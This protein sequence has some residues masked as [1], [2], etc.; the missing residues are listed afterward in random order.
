MRDRVAINN[1][2]SLVRVGT[3]SHYVCGCG[4]VLSDGDSNF[5]AGCAV[6][7]RSVDAIGPGYRSFATATMAQMCFREFFCPN[8]GTRLATEVAR[9]GDDYLWDIEIQL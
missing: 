9:R 4:R 7:E 2:L 3:G 8:C 5:K 6:A 1:N